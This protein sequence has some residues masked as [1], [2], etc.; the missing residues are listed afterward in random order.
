MSSCF[1]HEESVHRIINSTETGRVIF[2]GF[3]E[4]IQSRPAITGLEIPDV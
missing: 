1:I 3:H 2:G 4:S